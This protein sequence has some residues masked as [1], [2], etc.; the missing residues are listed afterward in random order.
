MVDI[1]VAGDVGRAPTKEGFFLID[2]AGR[3]I[4]EGRLEEVIPLLYEVL[5]ERKCEYGEMNS[6][7]S[8]RCQAS[9]ATCRPSGEIVKLCLCL[10]QCSRSQAFLVPAP[11]HVEYHE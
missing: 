3:K 1:E 7:C 9:H 11:F 2:I 10:K 5:E 6:E 8:K 4:R